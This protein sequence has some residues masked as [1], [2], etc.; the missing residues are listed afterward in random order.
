MSLIP[1][2]SPF[3]AQAYELVQTLQARLVAHL[4]AISTSAFQPIDWLRK[5]GQWGGGRRYVAANPRWFNRASINVS[6]V[7][8]DAEPKKPLASAT[9]LS[10]IVHPDHP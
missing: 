5:G 3:A 1:A 6:Q 2:K 10:T 4:E 9:A 8:Y 7:H